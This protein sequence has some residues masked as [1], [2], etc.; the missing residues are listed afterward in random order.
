MPCMSKIASF[1][2]ASDTVLEKSVY[3]KPFLLL[4]L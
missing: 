1:A 2:R 4:T 3:R